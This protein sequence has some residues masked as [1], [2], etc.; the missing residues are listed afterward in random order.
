[1]NRP[2][3]HDCNHIKRRVVS[4]TSKRKGTMP[5]EPRIH[6]SP[7]HCTCHQEVQS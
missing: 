1:M 3:C 6:K 5:A 7:C 2:R 4:A